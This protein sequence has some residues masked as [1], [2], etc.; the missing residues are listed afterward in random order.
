MS[1]DN[2]VYILETEGPEYRV[3]EMMAVDNVSWDCD[4]SCETN[5]FDILIKN[6]REMWSDAL[7]FT[8]RNEAIIAA[9]KL[10]DEVG[11]TEYGVSFIGIPKP[12]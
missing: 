11:Y 2:G 4:L 6:A 8:D 12:F 7:V 5:D 1:A 9:H 10:H 3:A